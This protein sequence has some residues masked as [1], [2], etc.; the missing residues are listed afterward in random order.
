MIEAFFLNPYAVLGAV[1]LAA[2]GG[3]IAWRNNHA[4]RVAVA[5][6]AFRAAFN[7]ALLRLT[8]S[9]EAGQV[10]LA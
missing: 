10:G 3:F 4:N 1:L 9:R 5:S 8:A 2:F 7:D 6:A